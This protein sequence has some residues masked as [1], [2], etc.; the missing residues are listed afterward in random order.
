MSLCRSN[1]PVQVHV[2][3]RTVSK[4]D[5]LIAE[6]TMGRIIEA[7]VLLRRI[8]TVLDDG[9]YASV[10]GVHVLL[11][12]SVHIDLSYH[13]NYTLLALDFFGLDHGDIPARAPNYKCDRFEMGCQYCDVDRL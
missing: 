6:L 3:A 2:M 4:Q 8:D 11:K 1:L 12:Q 10:S 7:R 9:S 13:Q 5:D